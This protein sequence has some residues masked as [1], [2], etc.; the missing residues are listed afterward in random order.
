VAPFT[1]SPYAIRV[2]QGVFDTNAEAVLQS[3]R[4]VGGS[5]AWA[6][7]G[8]RNWITL[9]SPTDPNLA[10]LGLSADVRERVVT[11]LRSGDVVVAPRGPVAVAGGS[12][13]GWWQIDR[14]TG[15][16]LGMG[17]SGWGQ[18]L[19]E[20]ALLIY[21]AAAEGFMFG[22][23]SCLITGGSNCIRAGVIGGAIS[24]VTAGL[25][26]GFAGALGLSTG[27][28]GI[29]TG[30][31]GEEGSLGSAAGEV[32]GEAGAAGGEGAGAG[33]GAGG[34]GGGAGGG[35]G[36][37]GGGGAGGGAGGPT[38]AEQAAAFKKYAGQAHAFDPGRW[39][40]LDEWLNNPNATAGDFPKTG[41]PTLE[42]GPGGEWEL[43]DPPP[44]DNRTGISPK[45][46]DPL[47]P[48]PTT[49][50]P[51]TPGA[52][53]SPKATTLTTVGNAKTIPAGEGAPTVGAGSGTL[54]LLPGCAAP[55]T[56]GGTSTLVGLGGAMN[57]LGGS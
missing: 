24:G 8:A 10:S 12:F 18:S 35:S 39:P 48:G 14:Q 56:P 38:P 31:A 20:Y 40:E 55:C 53:V 7:D 57:A 6:Y 30:L 4:P 44:T 23:L 43:R 42:Q 11:A 9:T 28:E 5:A 1:P 36:A 41:G 52:P 49:G 32:G 19:P 29:L 22:F 37:G 54:P 51:T 2:L 46:Y 50:T 3:D 17:E 15:E 33:G 25:G 27:G 26:L 34:G 16:T 21:V 47:G 45:A 13:S